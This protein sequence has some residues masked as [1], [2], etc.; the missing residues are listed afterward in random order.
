LFNEA[1]TNLAFT[2]QVSYFFAIKRQLLKETGPQ[3]PGGYFWTGRIKRLK[4]M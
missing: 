2:S 1:G 4:R 3:K